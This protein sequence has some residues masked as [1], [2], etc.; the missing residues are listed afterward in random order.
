MH[1]M[2]FVMQIADKAAAAA[3]EH[4]AKSVLSVSI[5]VG[6]MTGLVPDY[7]RRYWPYAIKDTILEGAALSVE[8]RETK[9]QCASCGK[10]Y[11]PCRENRYLCPSCGASRGKLLQGREFEILSVIITEEEQS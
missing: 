7:L 4:G 2:S 11:H 5:A 6:E 3:K 1:E 9:L 10:T 8:Y